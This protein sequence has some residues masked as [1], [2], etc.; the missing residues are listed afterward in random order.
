L[1]DRRPAFDRDPERRPELARAAFFA[2]VLEA[3]DRLAVFRAAAEPLREVCPFRARPAAAFEDLRFDA[4]CERRLRAA[5]PPA[6][7][8]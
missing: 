2:L 4:A 8:L 5:A 3:P 6:L 1:L 7:R